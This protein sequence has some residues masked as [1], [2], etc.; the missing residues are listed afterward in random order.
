[1]LSVSEGRTATRLALVVS[2]SRK[3]RSAVVTV[4]I[5]HKPASLL[6]LLEAL[7]SLMEMKRPPGCLA[8]PYEVYSDRFNTYAGRLKVPTATRLA[9]QDKSTFWR[10]RA[11]AFVVYYLWTLYAKYTAVSRLK[12]CTFD[13]V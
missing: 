2:S 6:A 3:H 7:G 5:Q 1:M 9:L 11:L 12:S 13:L 8:A 10:D 4:R